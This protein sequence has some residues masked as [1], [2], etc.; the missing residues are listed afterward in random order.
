MSDLSI[1]EIMKH[2][3]NNEIPSE[4]AVDIMKDATMY[5]VPLE[6]V[7]GCLRPLD[8]YLSFVNGGT[9][10]SELHDVQLLNLS[11]QVIEDIYKTS[12]L[13][14]EYDVS[15]GEMSIHTLDRILQREIYWRN[16]TM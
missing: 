15:F 14:Y 12:N 3:D 7:N 9:N 4:E 1:L 13:N 5:E 6:E 16:K 8:C 11:K 10:L 2:I